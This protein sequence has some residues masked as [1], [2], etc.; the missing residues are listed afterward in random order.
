M[1]LLSIIILTYNEE[2]NIA[3][4]LK[5]ISNL[6]KKYLKEIII[7]DSQSTDKTVNIVKSFQ[8]IIKNIRLIKIKKKNFDFGKTRN[9]AVKK[10]KGSYICFLSAD[11]IPLFNNK[12]IEYLKEDFEIDKKVVCVYG[13]QLPYEKHDYYYQLEIHCLFNKLDILLRQSKTTVLI[14]KKD[15]K[16]EN[17]QLLF[18]LSNVFS[19]YK[20]SFL[21]KY[22]FE[23]G[24]F[25]DLKMGKLIIENGFIKIY[26][27]RLIVKHSH[28]FTFKEYI[29]RQS[30]EI[31]I[32]NQL[33]AIKQINLGCK[34]KK[35]IFSDINF[36]DKIILFIKILFFYTAK[37]LIVIK[38][39]IF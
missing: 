20:K 28:N 24:G 4:Q 23:K 13:K 10:A 5:K 19:I 7:I 29:K 35:I 30:E 1:A 2:K 14:Q 33:N 32:L 39:K 21:V 11:A 34:I 31:K 17:N 18:F 22:P 27:P 3:K 38:N 37:A 8:K 12:I 15:I 26:D 25:E 6:S 9:L 16:T 36:R